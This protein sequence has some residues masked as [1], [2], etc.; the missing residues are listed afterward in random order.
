MAHACT[1]VPL[2][3]NSSRTV[4]NFD[5]VFLG[6]SFHLQRNSLS[7]CLD[8]DH[9]YLCSK[10]FVFAVRRYTY[11][12][13]QF[14]VDWVIYWGDIM[15]AVPPSLT[16]FGPSIRKEILRRRNPNSMLPC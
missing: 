2:L 10:C 5:D 13:A 4:D 14:G 8:L 3:R 11:Q 16:V 15:E 9:R 6:R 7:I 12:D 1:N